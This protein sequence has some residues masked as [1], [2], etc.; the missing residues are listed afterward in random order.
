LTR[1][2]ARCPN[3]GVEHDDARI[4][5]CEVCGTTL[6]NW[7]RVH[8]PAIGWLAGPECPGC[9]E[10]LDARLASRMRPPPA[11]PAPAPAPAP[12]PA[13]PPRRRRT[14][15]APERPRV[16]ERDPREVMLERAEELRPYVTTGAGVA[17][18]LVRALFAVVRNVIILALL[19]GIAGGFV[20]YNQGGD[21][22]WPV[23]TGALVGGGLGLLI[24]LISAIRIL[25]A[26]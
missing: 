15:P 22:V 20:A 24:G 12:E 14:R 17:V 8:S 26:E 18:R 23:I 21:L 4:V 10:E 9:A 2:I 11:P 19:G 5:E 7:C 1:I 6:R 16:P 3:C 13:P 25:F